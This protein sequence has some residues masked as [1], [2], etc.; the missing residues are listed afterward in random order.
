MLHSKLLLKVSILSKQTFPAKPNAVPLIQ[1][2]IRG[3]LF[4]LDPYSHFM[5]PQQVDHFHKQNKSQFG[6]M[7]IQIAFKNQQIIVTTVFKNSNADKKGVQ[8]GDII[9]HVNDQPLKSL[10]YDSALQKMK[11]KIGDTINLKLKKVNSEKLISLSI[12][13]KKIKI[14]S[15]QGIQIKP[16]LF[17]IQISS[18]RANTYKELKKILKVQACLKNKTTFCSKANK[19][20]LLDLRQNSGGLIDPALLIADLFISEG[21]LIS[22]KGKVEIHNQKFYAK[23]IGTLQP[24]PIV[25]LID[26]YTASASEILTSALKDNQQA[27]VVGKTSFGKGSIQ[28][29]FNLEDG[30]SLKLTV[31]HYFTP[32]GQA[33]EKKGIEPNIKLDHSKEWK[34]SKEN[35]QKIENFTYHFFL[36]HELTLENQPTKNSINPQWKSLMK[37]DLDLQ[38]AFQI[39]QKISQT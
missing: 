2:A 16:G 21:L 33:I 12:P 9:T 29:L 31:A 38:K 30:Y 27:F 5:N 20:L 36:N 35:M 37:E 14:P 15:V 17:Y 39:L 18:F 13:L 8:A 4:E 6:G 3:M 7:G 19:G 32:N 1:G 24:L 28:T 25:I 34:V 23:T 10:S 22:T 26:S 11:G